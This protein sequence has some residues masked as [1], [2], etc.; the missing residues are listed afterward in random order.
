MKLLRKDLKHNTVAVQVQGADD[1]WHLS[2]IIERGD[3]ISAETQRKVKAGEGETA[4]KKTLY[5]MILVEK[6]AYDEASKQLR[7]LGTTTTEHEEVPKGSY[8]TIEAEPGTIITIVKP[9]WH[10]YQLDRIDE[11]TR[12][13]FSDTL[14]CLL[15]RESA[16][17]AI[18]KSH[19]YE[20]LVELK[21][22]VV[23][24]YEGKM[25]SKDFYPEVVAKLKEY[26]DRF[27]L[28]NIIV[29]SPAFW[30]EELIKE[31]KDDKIL[32]KIR[33]STVNT[34]DRSGLE[35]V[36]KRPELKAII[37]E[38][39]A[40]KEALAVEELLREI[41][42][43]GMAAYGQLEV[44]KMAEIGGVRTLLITSGLISI[45]KAEGSFDELDEI[46]RNVDNAK[47]KVFII[48]SDNDAGKKLDA[49]SGIAAI[50]R[51]RA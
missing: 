49:L 14:I 26:S 45:R 17:I 27:E 4:V 30:K 8:Q 23:K 6:I 50:L 28:T 36:L 40:A 19:G 46:M 25:S 20:V 16:I 51:F 43:A 24:K 37:G 5:L 47:G 10:S 1:L 33:T 29:A 11:A 32:K 44:K 21:G 13:V 7:F 48:N 39:R 9:K 3:T 22:E 41:G 31:I 35:E 2:S 34:V 12:T 42:G 18:L 38:D 15:D